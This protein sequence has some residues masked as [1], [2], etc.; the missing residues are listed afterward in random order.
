MGFPK[1]CLH[2]LFGVLELGSDRILSAH[3][4]SQQQLWELALASRVLYRLAA[5]TDTCEA[6]LRFCRH[7]RDLFVT[8]LPSLRR[9][10]QMEDPG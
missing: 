9:F 1:T 2:A 5:S 3:C 7:S 6:T 10:P 8:Q 4:L